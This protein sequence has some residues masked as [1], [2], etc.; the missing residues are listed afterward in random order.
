MKKI[1]AGK[2]KI[3]V[4]WKRQTSVTGYQLRYST[5]ANM[6]KAKLIKVNG[7]AGNKTIKKLKAK[8][9]YYVQIRAYKNNGQKNIYGKWSTKKAIKTK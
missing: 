7:K 8:K 2:K 4:S 3:A 1:K 5:K 6:K 9:R